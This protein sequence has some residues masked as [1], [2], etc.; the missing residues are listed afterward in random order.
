MCSHR[1]IAFKRKREMEIPRLESGS[2]A[3]SPVVDLANTTCVSRLSYSRNWDASDYRGGRELIFGLLTVGA[4]YCCYPRC[5]IRATDGTESS[6]PPRFHEIVAYKT[7]YD[8]ETHFARRRGRGRRWQFFLDQFV[9]K[10]SRSA[11]G[12]IPAGTFNKWDANSCLLTRLESHPS[13]GR[14]PTTVG[15]FT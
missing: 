14:L 9:R 10:L 4:C 13:T 3:S 15:T 7:V 11:S 12:H 8:V 1:N 6:C 5:N 2:L